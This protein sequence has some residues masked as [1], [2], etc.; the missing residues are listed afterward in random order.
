MRFVLFGSGTLEDP[1]YTDEDGQDENDRYHG[2]QQT[3]KSHACSRLPVD[4]PNQPDS[5]HEQQEE[6]SDSESHVC[7]SGKFSQVSAQA[8][9][10]TVCLMSILHAKSR[11]CKLAAWLSK[12]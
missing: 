11:L 12:N 5:H 1:F 3:Q 6:R 9:A 10:P 8:F 2:G 7:V 4:R